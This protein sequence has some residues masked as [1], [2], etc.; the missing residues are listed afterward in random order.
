MLAIFAAFSNC[1]KSD[2]TL[3]LL[4]RRFIKPCSVCKNRYFHN[5]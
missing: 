3:Q 1:S 2:T 5:L 4:K